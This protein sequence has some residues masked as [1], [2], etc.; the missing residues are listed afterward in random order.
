MK[1]GSKI[2][3]SNMLYRRAYFPIETIESPLSYIIQCICN[4]KQTNKKKDTHTV[5][6]YMSKQIVV[7]V[8]LVVQMLR[9]CFLRV[10]NDRNARVHSWFGAGLQSGQAALL[11][12]D[13][14]C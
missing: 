13:G 9:L 5:A 10:S 6:P 12:S 2:I 8:C 7:I 11:Q 1:N 3:Y 4:K 14:L